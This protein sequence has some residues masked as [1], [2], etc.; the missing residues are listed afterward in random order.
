M[1]SP[2]R[3]I[4]RHRAPKKPRSY[5]HLKTVGVFVTGLALGSYVLPGPSPASAGHQGVSPQDL[6]QVCTQAAGWP[7]Q[8]E[9]DFLATCVGAFTRPTMSPTG[10]PS[11]SPTATPSSPPS[12]STSPSPNPSSS[13]TAVPSPSTSP[14]VPSPT[15]APP[16]PVGTCVKPNATSTGPA[17]MTILTPSGGLTI[18]NGQTV[19][20]REITGHVRVNSGGVLLH[21]RIHGT[22]E[23][24][25]TALAE[26][27][28]V[29][30]NGAG[31]AVFAQG[32]GES[33]R[34]VIRN[35]EIYDGYDGARFDG[36]VL[37]ERSWIH[38]LTRTSGAHGDGVQSTKG[39]YQ[40]YR[41][42]VVEGGNTSSF[43]IANEGSDPDDNPAHVVFD[44]NWFVGTSG[45]GGTTSY[46][47]YANGGASDFRFTS[48]VFSRVGGTVRDYPRDAVTVWTDNV[49]TDGVAV[50][51][52]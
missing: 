33:A 23:L 29:D 50:P 18:G 11:T 1:F 34:A 39:P 31:F 45:V 37:M 47:V 32:S 48:N 25:G 28:E 49:F 3:V 24:H 44:R 9:P 17:P 19:S 40:T 15:S 10:A 6:R 16:P 22:L 42:N 38:A 43:I 36:Y 21:S 30:G 26:H 8:S 2:P 5:R 51:H 20:G 41:C 13:P 27:I 14:P 52:P 4:P 12:P 7:G 46:A 35:A